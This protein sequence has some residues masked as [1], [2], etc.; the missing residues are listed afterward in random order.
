[1]ADKIGNPNREPNEYIEIMPLNGNV[2]RITY[3]QFSDSLKSI[4]ISDEQFQI[5][6]SMFGERSEETESAKLIRLIFDL[7]SHQRLEKIDK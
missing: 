1:M 2:V 4:I 3:K 7:Q 6:E 5:T